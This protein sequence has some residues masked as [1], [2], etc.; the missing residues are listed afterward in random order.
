[1]NH[2]SFFLTATAISSALVACLKSTYKLIINMRYP[3]FHIHTIKYQTQVLG[4]E[5]PQD[6]IPTSHRW[7]REYTCVVLLISFSLPQFSC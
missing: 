2:M 3:L 5:N 1:M 7:Y 6:P 4:R